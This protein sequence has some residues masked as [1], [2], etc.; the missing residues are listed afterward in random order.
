MESHSQ[1]CGNI[2]Y[3]LSGDP[4]DQREQTLTK[5][6]TGCFPSRQRE[7]QV[8]DDFWDRLDGHYLA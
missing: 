4:G 1:K 7:R 8:L 5:V 2:S 3:V 6:K